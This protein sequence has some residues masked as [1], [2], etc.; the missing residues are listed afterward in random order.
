MIKREL[1]LEIIA[2]IFLGGFFG[3]FVNTILYRL[4]TAWVGFGVFY[5]LYR[6]MNKHLAIS[7][8][9]AFFL[10]IVAGTI[11]NSLYYQNI[12]II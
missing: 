10:G 9:I 2:Y 8:V 1:V 6:K 3:L 12:V 11:F 4:L 5:Y 7:F